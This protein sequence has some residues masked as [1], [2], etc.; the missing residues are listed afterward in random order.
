MKKLIFFIF[1]GIILILPTGYSYSKNNNVTKPA[2]IILLPNPRRYCLNLDEAAEIAGFNFPV[3]L[4]NYYE[5]KASE[6]IMEIKYMISDLRFVFLRKSNRDIRYG[7]ISGVY[8]YYPI[9]KQIKLKGAVPVN[10]RAKDD[11]IYVMYMSNST[12]YYS[13]YCQEGMSLEEIEGIY[14]ILAEAEAGNLTE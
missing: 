12:Y 6:G 8:T 11:K 13:V 10:I 2:N 9:D 1:I 5:I 4:K 7:D 3:K 14:N